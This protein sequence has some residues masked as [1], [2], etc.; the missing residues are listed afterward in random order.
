MTDPATH[1]YLGLPGYAWMWLFAIPAF[2][3]FW[4]RIVQIVR[5]L[6]KA[7]PEPRWDR[8][9]ERT[10]QVVKNVFG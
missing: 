7:R 10:W 1:T 6:R 4:R 8:I 2:Y 5:L 3:L 9:P